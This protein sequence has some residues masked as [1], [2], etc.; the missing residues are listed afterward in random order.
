MKAKPVNSVVGV[1]QTGSENDA[2]ELPEQS[3]TSATI[4]TSEVSLNKR[5]EAVDE[6][7]NDVAQGLRHHDQPPWSSSSG[8]AQRARRLAL[9]ARGIACRP[10]R[11]TSGLIGAGKQRDADQGPHQPIHREA[12]RNEQRQHVGCEKQHR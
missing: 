10:P 11:I 6:A 2:R 1:A 3:R 12:R 4:E 9:P 7:G 5:D 8:Q